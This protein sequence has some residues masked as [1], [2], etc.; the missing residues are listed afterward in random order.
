MSSHVRRTERI[1]TENVDS[2]KGDGIDTQMTAPLAA[3]L[4]A[5]EW[6][7]EVRTT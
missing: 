5:S 1:R 4:L 3:P 6:T 2:K 7:S